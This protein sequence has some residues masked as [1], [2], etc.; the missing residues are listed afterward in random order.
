LANQVRVPTLVIWGDLDTKIPPS[1]IQDLLGDLVAAPQKVFVH[2]AC[3]SHYLVWENQ[4]MNL[5][6]A[7]VEWLRHGTYSGQFNGT[8]AVDAAGEVHQ[9]QWTLKSAGLFHLDSGATAALYGPPEVGR[10]HHR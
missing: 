7:S 2:V 3:P 9:E 4:H 6:D 10:R 1:Q 8:F 5:L